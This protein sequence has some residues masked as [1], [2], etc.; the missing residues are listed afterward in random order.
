MSKPVVVS[1][2]HHLGREEAVRRLKSGLER[3]RTTFGSQFA[4]LEENWSG[5]HLDLRV[6]ILGQATGGSID[7]AD[8]HV[9]IAI[10]LPW[11]LGAVAEKA[12]SLIQRQGQLM[13]E[14]K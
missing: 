9:R 5:E 13:L 11:L 10:E 7:V 3:T 2:P 6:A 12:K 14:K 4:V 8:D 1:I